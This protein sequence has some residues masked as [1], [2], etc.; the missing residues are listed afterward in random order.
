MTNPELIK[1]L[2]SLSSIAKLKEAVYYHQDSAR[3]RLEDVAFLL[4]RH[5]ELLAYAVN[6]GYHPLHDRLSTH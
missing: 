3:L 2:S 5:E 1:K 6:H 4:Q